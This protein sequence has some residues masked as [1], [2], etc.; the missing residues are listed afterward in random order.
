MRY[1]FLSGDSVVHL[2]DLDTDDDAAIMA[3]QFQSVVNIT[4]QNPEPTLGWVLS[5]GV[6][7]DPT[8]MA[9]TS[10]YISKEKF[11]SRFTD[12]ELIAI[13]TFANGTSAPAMALRV[14]MRKQQVAE[15]IDLDYDKTVQGIMG[16][17]AL[18]LLTSDRANAIIYTPVTETERYKGKT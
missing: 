3:R 4:G 16:L 8:G 12:A 13:E 10:R 15:Y 2:A 17:V 18:G 11:L 1:A 14:S 6:L 7:I 9:K 5:N